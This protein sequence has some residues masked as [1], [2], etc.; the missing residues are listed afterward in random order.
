MAGQAQWGREIGPVRQPR[1]GQCGGGF[2][3]LVTDVPGVRAVA[4]PRVIDRLVAE[5]GRRHMIT[6][7]YAGTDAAAL[8]SCLAEG[9]EALRQPA[10]GA[11]LPP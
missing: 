4:S 2:V 6:D 8:F 9:F 5:G 3:C 11:G 1:R 10:W 7:G